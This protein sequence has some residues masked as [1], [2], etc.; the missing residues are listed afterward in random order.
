MLGDALVDERVVR[1][2]QVHDIA[3]LAPDAVEEHPRLVLEAGAQVVVEIRELHRV[4][5]LRLQIAQEQP[6]AGKVGRQPLGPGIGQHAPDLALEDARRAQPPLAGHLEELIV[7][8]A[9]PE[10]E[11]QPRRQL[12]VG[13][14]VRLTDLH[15]LR[16]ALHAEH[17]L[18]TGQDALDAGFDA[19]L[20]SPLL[21]RLAVERHQ[22]LRIRIGGLAAIGAAGQPGEDARGAC[23]LNLR[24]RVRSRTTAEDPLPARRVAA[25]SWVVGAGDRERQHVRDAQRIARIVR[26]ADRRGH[27]IGIGDRAPVQPRHRDVV[28]ARRQAYLD[29]RSLVD[30]VANLRIVQQVRRPVVGA[31]DLEQVDALAVHRV[32]HVVLVLEAAHHAEIG[33]E[34]LRRQGV[35]ALDLNH[36]PGQ[37]SA[38]RAER[39]T[40]DVA[41]LRRVLAQV[42]HLRARTD[43]GATDRQ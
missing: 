6:L 38:D 39:Q 33:A 26:A 11:G 4:G 12:V 21:A 27:A 41:I 23:L 32:L 37:Q 13:Q 29:S 9:A 40:L 43:V 28:R 7:G 5:L 25:A 10:E 19:G 16:I 30:L 31:S 36:R 34:E 15:G 3:I 20:E 2:H 17:E 35:V 14:R 1:V 18:R 42:E 8:D 22:P 24:R